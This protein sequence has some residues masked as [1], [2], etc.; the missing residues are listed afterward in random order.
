MRRST[1]LLPRFATA[2]LSLFV[3]GEAMAFSQ[4]EGENGSFSGSKDGIIAVPLPPLPGSDSERAGPNPPAGFLDKKNSA[5]PKE[6][7]R[8]DAVPADNSGD[9]DQEM[10]GTDQGEVPIA[11]E[12]ESAP[13]V[14]RP[15]DGLPARLPRGDDKTSTP[16]QYQ[17][18]PGKQP[19]EETGPR[20]G[21]PFGNGD[22]QTDPAVPL[23]AE[24]GYGTEKLPAPVRELREK[25]MEAAKTGDI[26]K[27]RPMIATGEDGTVVSFGE[28]PKDPIDF[29]K[30]ASGDGEGIE[31]LAILVDILQSGY[32]RVEPN[33]DDEIYVWPYF[34]QVDPSR[35]TKP[36]LVELF[37]IV[38]AGDY[39]SM[40]D[41]G[42]YNFYR[43]G[44]TPDGKL[45]FFVAGD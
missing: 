15:G 16:A 19:T 27:L 6:R 18:E 32:A 21:R 28:T 29:L 1:S 13:A 26:E 30:T 41:F 23:A 34:T 7:H 3:A 37:E 36:Q 39:Q 5:D 14:T 38:T 4:F 24:I 2:G 35:L 25:L 40:I 43:V 45:Q 31:I 12:D 8:N 11:P 22:Q 17:A 33:S 42:A 44:I 20:V 9:D 10:E